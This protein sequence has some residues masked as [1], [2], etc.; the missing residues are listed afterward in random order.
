MRR[1]PFDD[2]AFRQFL[3]KV[4]DSEWIVSQQYDD[5]GAQRGTYAS[6][7]SF[8]QW[9]PPEPWETDEFEGISIPTLEFPGEAGSF[10]LNEKQLSTARD[11]LVNHEEAKHDYTF[12][13]GSQSNTNAPDGKQLHV[14]GKPLT[15]A[16]TNNAGEAGQGPITF[17]YQ[18][19]GEDKT[20][21]ATGEQFTSLLRRVG[22][23]V[24]KS[25]ESISKTALAVYYQENFDMYSMGWSLTPYLLAYAP[26]YGQAG[27]DTGEENN[28][29]RAYYNPMGYTGAQDLIEQDSKLME[30]SERIPVV[31]KIQAKIWHDAPT[32]ITVYKNL[33]EPHPAEY[34]GFYTTAGGLFETPWMNVYKEDSGE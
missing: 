18:P 29:D 14:N 4:F 24:R 22:I 9:R 10:E 11:F 33:L 27:V 25:V 21:N 1:V 19:P 32:I 5:I 30:R 12:E 15:E 28:T 34:G 16:H 20:Q 31:K 23:P 3:R 17:R 26:L 6:L 13:E 2:I 8:K 7:A